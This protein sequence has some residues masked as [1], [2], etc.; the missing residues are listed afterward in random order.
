MTFAH[1]APPA[2][3]IPRAR[4]RAATVL[5]LT[6]AAVFPALAQESGRLPFYYGGSVTL[7]Q[8]SNVTRAPSNAAR[9]DT[10]SIVGLRV[11]FDQPISRQRVF[12]DVSLNTK[13]YSDTST[14]NGEGYAIA[15]GMDWSTIGR[16]SGTLRVDATQQQA[17]LNAIGGPAIDTRNDERAQQ[18]QAI[19][20]WGVASLFQ[21]EGS[22]V[23]NRLDYSNS[24]AGFRKL[25]Q[26]TAGLRVI[27]SPS[28]FIS[29]GAGGRVGEGRYPRFF[30]VAPGVGSPL[31]FDRRDIDF[32]VSYIPTGLTRLDGRLSST[33]V[34][35]QQD[36]SRDVSGVTGA[37]TWAYRPTGRISLSSTLFRE[38]GAASSFLDLGAAGRTPVGS[39]SQLATG[40]RVAVNYD[41]T[42][43]VQ[44]NTGADWTRRTYTGSLAGDETLQQIRFGATW[45]Y[46]RV[47]S[48][49]CGFAHETRDG[50]APGVSDYSANTT[51]C[52]AQLLLR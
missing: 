31:D 6:L 45:A 43:K 41:L 24:L 22:Y 20:R 16:L 27:Y 9:S 21:V 18:F 8:D 7:G 35:Y 13:R 23:V 49:A 3:M 46:S 33:Q 44:L 39:T 4:A 19:G 28:A 30:S 1:V 12:G 38:T 5:G 42:G 26:D 29:F 17:E 40:L 51:Q 47:I 50:N 32:T 15:L 48:F 14:L 34:D 52:S 10:F 25:E 36:P 2:S 37:L 11:G